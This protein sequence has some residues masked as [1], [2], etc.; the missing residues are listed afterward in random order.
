MKK[1]FNKIISKI[2]LFN[3]F[4]FNKWVHINV[5]IVFI[6]VLA[7]LINIHYADNIFELIKESVF[8]SFVT[9]FWSLLNYF[10]R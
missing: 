6:M 10:R 3:K 4:V 9:L 1:L 8:F 5:Y 2:N 7:G